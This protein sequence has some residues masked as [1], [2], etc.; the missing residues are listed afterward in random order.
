MHGCKC[1]DGYDEE[2]NRYHCSITGDS[3]F[4]LMPNGKACAEK[5]GE[6]SETKEEEGD[7]DGI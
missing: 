6:D 1:C 7:K 3:C 2:D 5:F 4:F